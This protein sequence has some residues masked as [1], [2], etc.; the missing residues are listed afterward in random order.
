MA[1]SPTYV[2]A[3]PSVLSV[4]QMTKGIATLD[5]RIIELEKFDPSTADN[6]VLLAVSQAISEAIERVFG[7]GTSDYARYFGASKLDQGPKYISPT[8]EYPAGQRITDRR[9]SWRDGKLRSLVILRQAVDVLKERIAEAE[10]VVWTPNTPSSI[11]SNNHV[12]IVHG[13]DGEMK[14]AV[15]RFVETLGLHPVILDEQAN[16]GQTI[17]EKFE[18]HSSVGYAIVLMSPDDEGNRK[19]DPVSPRARQNVVLELGYFA[20]KLGRDRVCALVRG[21]EIELPSDISGLVWV[22]YD[23]DWQF[24]LA[25]ELKAA[26]FEIDM[27]KVF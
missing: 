18:Q 26:K 13:H 16:Q 11:V 4:E 6:H 1:N 25:K 20:G 17:I 10:P 14:H 23:S 15:A 3:R 19:G 9:S 24:K 22:N 27:N 5:K 8:N 21:K 7:V 12:F 2:S